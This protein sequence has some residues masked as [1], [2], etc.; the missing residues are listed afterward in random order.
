MNTPP[1]PDQG[2]PK[3]RFRYLRRTAI[4]LLAAFTLSLLLF[5]GLWRL[6]QSPRVC[7]ATARYIESLV[8]R[9]SSGELEISSL[10]W[11]LFPP[12]LKLK[13]VEFKGPE[14]KFHLEKAGINLRGFHPAR[15]SLVFSTVEIDGLDIEI[16]K[17]PDSSR[18]RNG[19]FPLD[20]VIDNLSLRRVSFNGHL[21]KTD[22]ELHGGEL[23]WVREGSRNIG[24]FRIRQCRL[25]TGKMD[26]MQFGLAGSFSREGHDYGCKHLLISGTDFNLQFCGKLSKGNLAGNLKGK[27]KLRELDRVIRAHH[28]LQ[29]DINFE[30]DIDTGRADPLR[31]HLKSE[32]LIVA[33]AFPLKNLEGD[34]S[35]FHDRLEGRLLHARFFG[36]DLHGSYSL[37]SFSAFSHVME[38]HCRGMDLGRLLKVLHVPPGGLS[39]GMD[40]SVSTQWKG[41]SFPR[42]EGLAD[43]VFSSR[44]GALPVSGGLTLALH[45]ENFLEFDSQDLHIGS[46]LIELQ[47]PLTLSSWRPAWAI[48]AE[49]LQLGEVLP[50]VNRWVGSEIFPSEISGVGLLDLSLD[51]PWSDL[52][53]GILLDAHNLAYP[54]I[55]VDRVNIEGLIAGGRFQLKNGQFRL[56]KGAGTL[57]GFISWNDKTSSINKNMLDLVAFGELWMK[58]RVHGRWAFSRWRSM[59]SP[60][61]TG[62]PRSLLIPA[63]SGHRE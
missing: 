38:A 20:L 15:R 16:Q 40:V 2:K 6:L 58:P 5:L 30:M 13:D 61:E 46:S 62:Q 26:E 34:I 24:F 31:L 9:G 57:K 21:L 59:E 4:A 52:R 45:G 44:Q 29:G 39:A 11:Q 32:K 1:I 35:L 25:K 14:L 54:P 49:P 60:V 63:L 22:L 33:K 41:R 47:G 51:G 18:K 27:L 23:A 48:H 42:G 36:G 56:G 50:A 55:Q 17:T 8:A 37:G 28:L 10:S 12:R 19:G 43:I 7:E 53:V 3:R